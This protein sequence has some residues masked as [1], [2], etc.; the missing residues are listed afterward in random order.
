MTNVLITG[1]AGFIGSHVAERCLREG[2]NVAV[3][4]DLSTGNLSNIAAMKPDPRFS[5]TLGSA[6]DESL[7]GSMVERSDIVFSLAATVGVKLVLEGPIRALDNN[8]QGTKC[9]LEAAA[10]KGTRVLV[11]STSEVYGKSDRVPFCEDADLVIG[12]TSTLRWGYACSKALDEFLAMAY[13][14]EYGMPVTVVR[15]FNTAGP[16]QREE[17]GMVLPAFVR[18]ALVGSPITVFGDGLQSRCFTH[19]DDVAES[20][21]RL[22]KTPEASGEVVNVGN[23]REITI[24]E[25]AAMVRDRTRSSSKIVRVPYQEAYEKGFE[26]ITRRVPSVAKLE[27]IIGYRPRTPLERIVDTLAEDMRLRIGLDK[28]VAACG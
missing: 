9:V 13:H 2:W 21:V 17:Y 19:V 5:F 6:L 11:A 20:L 23:D 1:G 15:I 26:E 18:Q 4:D 12:K 28:C 7:V 16:R 25:L 14:H 22:V 27:R 10:R 8:V 3:L 24:G